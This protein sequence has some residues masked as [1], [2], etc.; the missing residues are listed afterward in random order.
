MPVGLADGRRTRRTV[1]YR[2]VEPASA[3]GLSCLKTGRLLDPLC[4]LF[5]KGKQFI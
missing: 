1:G 4:E 5:D 2:S 3:I